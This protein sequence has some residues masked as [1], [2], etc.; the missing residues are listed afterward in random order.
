MYEQF[1]FDGGRSPLNSFTKCGNGF[2]H[3]M[4][5]NRL[6]LSLLVGKGTF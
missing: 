3:H 4:V 2:L 5:R 1:F 6:A